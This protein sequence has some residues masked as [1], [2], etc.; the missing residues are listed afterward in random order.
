MRLLIVPLRYYPESGASPSRWTMLAENLVRKGCAVDVLT[1]V[2]NYPFARTFDGYRGRVFFCQRHNGCRIYRYWSYPTVSKNPL[3]RMANMFSSAFALRFFAVHVRRILS[4]DKVLIQSPPLPHAVSAMMLFKGIFRRKCVLNLSDIWPSTGVQMGAIKKGSLSYIY[5]SWCEKYLVRNADMIIGQS[6][7]ILARVRELPNKGK[8]FLFRN[9]P[10]R[11]PVSE[12]KTKSQVL[13]ICFAGM[14]GVAQDVLSVVKNIDFKSLNAELHIVGKGFQYD[15]IY[16]YVNNH[17][18]CNVFLH[19]LVEKDKM[20]G[21]YEQ[22]DVALVPLKTNIRGAFPS[23]LYDVLPS[24]IPVL[25]SGCGEPAEFVEK[26]ALGFV[27]APMD[28]D[29]LKNNILKMAEMSC[30]EYKSMS[31]N[32]IDICRKM[33]NYDK[34]LEDFIDW[35]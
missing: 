26:N 9:L 10:M 16:D 14:L 4:Y 24:G 35:L 3:K 19:G 32:C 22:Y 18:D 15:E 34:Q 28:F 2:P 30:E 13:K 20:A 7:E 1:S 33:F 11:E 8:L 17:G 21:L 23:K 27:S 25:Y 5:M 6:E 12:P 31:R 29:A